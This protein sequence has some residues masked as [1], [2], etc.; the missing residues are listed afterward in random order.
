MLQFRYFI[1]PKKDVTV[2]S[3]V[4]FT[5]INTACTSINDKDGLASVFAQTVK[6]LNISNV[7]KKSVIVFP[8]KVQ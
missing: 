2:M 6:S 3:S 8:C 5:A 7:L 1:E 4:L